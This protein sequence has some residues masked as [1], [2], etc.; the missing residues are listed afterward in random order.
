MLLFPIN[1]DFISTVNNIVYKESTRWGLTTN[2]KILNRMCL[3]KEFD[4]FAVFI[5]FFSHS[6]EEA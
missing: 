4:L 1:A 3:G 5:I 6:F 2:C